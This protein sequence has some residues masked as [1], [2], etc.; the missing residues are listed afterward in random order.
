MTATSILVMLAVLGVV[1]GGFLL[2]LFLA[3]SKESRKQ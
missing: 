2:C 1:W 3:L